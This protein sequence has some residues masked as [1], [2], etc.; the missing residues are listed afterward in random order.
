MTPLQADSLNVFASPACRY[1]QAPLPVE[2]CVK[3]RVGYTTGLAPV[4]RALLPG[5]DSGVACLLLGVFLLLAFNFRHYTTALKSFPRDLLSVRRRDNLFEEHTMNETRLQFSMITV[6]CLTE[7]ILVYSATAAAGMAL[8]CSAFT[9]LLI[10]LGVAA[11]Y[12]L[13]Q[14]AAYATAGYVFADKVT[15]R[16][17]LKGFNASQSLVGF[18]LVIPALTVVFNPSLTA[19]M[20]IFSLIFYLFGRLIFIYKGFRLFYDKIGSLVYFILYLC[21]LEVAPLLVM[22]RGYRFFAL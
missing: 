6:L 7:S 10:F 17:W 12:Y 11:V 8:R 18:L 4:E 14:L 1:E 9:A 16:L 2:G 20:V 15:S 22:A 3:G 13:V 21:T 19:T 5:Y